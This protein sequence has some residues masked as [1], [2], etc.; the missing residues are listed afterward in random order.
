MVRSAA[1]SAD[2]RFIVTASQDRTARVWDARTLKTL[3]SLEGHSGWVTSATF[4]RDGRFIATTAVGGTSHI[5]DAATGKQLLAL[6]GPGDAVWSAAFSPDG[7]LLITA[8]NDGT[9]QIWNTSTGKAIYT[10]KADEN[11]I[12]SAAF[13]SDGTQTVTGSDYGRARIWDIP[14]IM[15][16]P[17]KRQVEIACQRLQHVDAQ[18][19]FSLAD[20]ATYPVLRGIA[21]DKANPGF[22]VSPCRGV[23][24]A[25]AFVKAE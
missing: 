19:A 1:Y 4:S 6:Q 23:L 20:V 5:W 14:E 10:W 15:R 17:P 22:L 25:S 8:S 7:T 13:S 18:L 21:E 9:A 12:R 2:G 11:D 16:V 3:R 24:P